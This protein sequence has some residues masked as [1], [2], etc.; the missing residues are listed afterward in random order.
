MFDFRTFLELVSCFL[1]FVSIMLEKKAQR[2]GNVAVARP[3]I[4]LD[5]SELRER[6]HAVLAAQEEDA[7]ALKEPWEPVFDSLATVEL[8]C[9][10]EDIVPADLPASKIVRAGG[11]T[12]ASEAADDITKRIA[13]ICRLEKAVPA[14]RNNVQ[15]DIFDRHQSHEH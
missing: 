14:K 5:E 3:I 2:E 15:M 11:Y 12:S 9:C 4:P 6:I 7:A 10:V 8:I 1:S 13:A